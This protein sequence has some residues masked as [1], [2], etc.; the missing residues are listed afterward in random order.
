MSKSQVTDESHREIKAQDG[1]QTQF[2]ECEADICIFGGSPGGSKSYSILLDVLNGTHLPKCR[3]LIV[4]RQL[5][6]LTDDGGLIDDARDVFE[7]T[8]A[9][10]NGQKNTFKWP[11]GASVIFGHMDNPATDHLRYKS[12]QYARIYFEELTEFEE[13]QFWYMPSRNRSVCGIRPYIRATTNPHPGW[14]A[15]LL[16]SGGYV[17]GQ[18]GYAIEAMSGVIRWIVRVKGILYW[19]DSYEEA[20]KAFPDPKQK[21]LSFCFIRSKLSDNK[22]L[23]D[24]DPDYESKIMIMDGIESERLLDGNWLITPNKGRVFRREYFPIIPHAPRCH[25]YVRYWDKAATKVDDGKAGHDPDWTAGAL[26]GITDQKSYVILDI[27]RMR[28][29]PLDVEEFITMTARQDELQYGQTSHLIIGIEQEGGSAGKND[30]SHYTRLLAGYDVRMYPARDNKVLR[31]TPVAAQCKAGNVVM[32]EGAW[33][34]DFLSEAEAFP[35]KKH[36]DD[37]VDACSGAFN[38]LVEG[39]TAISESWDILANAF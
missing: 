37:Q 16:I 9:T 38:A 5:K 6:D 30:A 18:T 10:F 4:R 31:A 20:K 35:S 34:E 22:I 27:R 23:N 11:S 28:G 24:A 29:E 3:D 36:H 17:D 13:H 21:A 2:I 19:F 25:T 15:Q 7:A 32:V 39:N 26:W 33:N 12:K 1:P 14:V 8:G